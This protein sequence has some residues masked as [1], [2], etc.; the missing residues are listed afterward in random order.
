[1][2]ADDPRSAMDPSGIRL[3]TP[4][5]TTRGMCPQDMRSVADIIDKTLRD[6]TQENVKRQKQRVLELAVKFPVPGIDASYFAKN[7]LH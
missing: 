6:G 1:M 2:I 4:A 3:G 7:D 5:M